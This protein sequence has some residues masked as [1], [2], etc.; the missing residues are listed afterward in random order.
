MVAPLWL[1]GLFVFHC[2]WIVYWVP[3]V[4]LNLVCANAAFGEKVPANPPL[5][6]QAATAPLTVTARSWLYPAVAVHRSA[7]PESTAS[8]FAAGLRLIDSTPGSM[9]IQVW[10]SLLGSAYCARLVTLKR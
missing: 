6:F 7:L 8:K 1:V 5:S 2:S 4:M 3:A 10:P 9:S